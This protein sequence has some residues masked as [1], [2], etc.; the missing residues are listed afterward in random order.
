MIV[1]EIIAKKVTRFSFSFWF[2]KGKFS[3]SFKGNKE[4]EKKRYFNK[5]SLKK[6]KYGEFQTLK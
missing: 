2:E 6:I 4:K 3:S 5:I 1:M